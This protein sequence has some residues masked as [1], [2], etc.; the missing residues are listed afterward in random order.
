VLKP[1]S[2]NSAFAKNIPISEQKQIYAN[3]KTRNKAPFFINDCKNYDGSVLALFPNN[4]NL[5]EHELCEKLNFVNWNELG[6]ICDGRYVFSQ[7]SLENTLL[8]DDFRVYINKNE[9]F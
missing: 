5:D 7:K 1:S 9:M 8:P 2:G 6:F 3:C 4:Q